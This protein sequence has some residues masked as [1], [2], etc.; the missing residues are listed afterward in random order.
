[1]NNGAQSHLFSEACA[2]QVIKHKHEVLAILRDEGM[3]C[4]PIR[5]LRK[6]AGASNVKGFEPFTAE[7]FTWFV[8]VGCRA[9]VL[10]PATSMDGNSSSLVWLEA[11]FSV[12]QTSARQLAEIEHDLLTK[13]MQKIAQ[14][15]EPFLAGIR[16]ECDD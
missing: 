10:H 13:A 3:V 2:R 7:Q 15:P 12:S 1:M 5:Q 6:L 14:M 4:D 11:N 16:K 9:K 8:E